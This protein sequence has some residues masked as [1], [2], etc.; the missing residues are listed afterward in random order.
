[1][2]ESR[3]PW[4]CCA[5]NELT[6]LQ[7]RAGSPLDALREQ[8]DDMVAR[9]QSPERPRGGRQYR[10]RKAIG[11][12]QGCVARQ[13]ARPAILFRGRNQGNTLG[14]GKQFGMLVVAAKFCGSVLTLVHKR[15]YNAI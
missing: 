2:A 3:I 8:F 6:A 13:K 5:K 14:E 10:H 9:I 11:A 4:C 7:A 15:A 1:M 12:G